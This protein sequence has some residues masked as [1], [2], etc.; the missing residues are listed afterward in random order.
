MVWCY[1]C[2]ALLTSSD[3]FLV[4]DIGGFKVRAAQLM[5]LPPVL[6]S[7]WGAV[8]SS[9]NLRWP[10]GFTKLLLWAAFI[11]LFIPNTGFVSR[12]IGYA[13]WL[14]LSISLV[15]AA[16]QYL[17]TLS[18]VE[19]VFR[20]YL[21]S[22][23]L[24][25]I[26]GLM[27]FI[28]PIVG[29]HPPLVTEWWIE[30]RLARINGLTYEPSYFASYMLTGWVLI[31]YLRMNGTT[32]MSSRWLNCLFV[33]VTASM[34][35][36]TSRVGWLMMIVWWILRSY[37]QMQSRG[38]SLKYARSVLAVLCSSVILLTLTASYFELQGSDLLFLTGG[39]GI[40]DETGEHSTIGRLEVAGETFQVFK[41]N[42]F[43]GVSLGGIAPAI[44]Q[45]R[46]EDVNDQDA[47]KQNEGQC[48]TAEVLAASGIIGIWPYLLYLWD[49]LV[50]PIRSCTRASGPAVL[51]KGLCWSLIALF[52]ILQF[53]QN[54]LRLYL[55][56]HIALLSAA[57]YVV[58]SGMGNK[59]GVRAMVPHAPR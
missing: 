30:G 33:L 51:A 2:A 28:M 56:F 4:L 38:M 15:W 42:P 35:L 45:L 17:E 52:T 23:G 57:C 5:L 55:W 41:H 10:L 12:N 37:W 16:T 36:S 46:G 43:I 32:V 24:S 59:E 7:I 14:L 20:W 26:I 29:L 21:Y 47:A 48:I 1:A 19:L 6:S 27:Q 18:D 40:V 22:F 50:V 34:L 8:F 58:R 9:K 11:V 3:L 44:G 39:L 49:I 25:A 31:D 13:V 53:N 54:I